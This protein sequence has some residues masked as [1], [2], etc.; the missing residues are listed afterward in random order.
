MRNDDIDVGYLRKREYI[1]RCEDCGYKWSVNIEEEEDEGDSNIE[2]SI[3]SS[4]E[5]FGDIE[6]SECPIC[7][8]DNIIEV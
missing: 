3:A 2:R 8:N 4:E 7:G 5:L 6:V 1:Y